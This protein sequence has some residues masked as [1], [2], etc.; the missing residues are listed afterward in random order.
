VRVPTTAGGFQGY[1]TDR[2]PHLVV[3]ES[4]THSGWTSRLLRQLGHT[5][6]VANP[7]RV[8]AISASVRKSDERDARCLAQLARVDPELL[9]PVHPR[10]EE[11]QQSLAVVRAREGLVKTRTQLINQ[12]RGM[13]KAFGARLPQSST[14]SFARRAQ[15]ALPEELRPWPRNGKQP[16]DCARFEGWGL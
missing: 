9:S 8:R 2:A 3:L 4:G 15:E 13:V 10:S 5:V 7:S 14:A 16:R 6:I 11:I 12:V 1:F